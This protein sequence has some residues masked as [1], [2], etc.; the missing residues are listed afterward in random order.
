M[1][2]KLSIVVTINVVLFFVFVIF[3]MMSKSKAHDPLIYLIILT[4]LCSIPF[5]LA[6]K[7]NGPYC[8][9]VIFSPVYFIYF[10]MTDALGYFFDLPASKSSRGMGLTDTEMAILLGWICLIIGYVLAV[11]LFSQTKLKVEK[12]WKTKHL[13]VLGFICTIIGWYALWTLQLGFAD[14][15]SHTK[16]DM[17]PIKGMILIIG[18][19]L[20]P[21]GAVLLVYAYLKEKS[22]TL[23]LIFFGICILKIPLAFVLDSKEIALQNLII[24]FA[25]KWFYDGKVPVRWLLVFF[26]GVS[27]LFPLFYAYRTA[28]FSSSGVTRE[29]AMA[30]MTSNIDKTLRRSKK[31]TKEEGALQSGIISFTGRMHLKPLVTLV[32]SRTGHGVPYQEG[33]TLSLLLYALI[34]RVILPNKDDSSIGQLFNR[35]FRISEDRNTYISS[36]FLAEFYWNYGWGGIIIGMLAVGTSFGLIGVK[37][38]IAEHKSVTRLLVLITTIYLLCFRFEAGVAIQYTQWIRA[39]I[40][41]L[42]LHEIFARP[43]KRI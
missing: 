5:L 26:V 42:I 33:Y 14:H 31:T 7:L 9:L 19:M 23:L 1:K 30:S 21:F 22:Q 25:A 24:F 17:G 18:K 4:F 38:N 35:Q 37:G 3:S 29:Q 10:G 32:I 43:V 41:V 40:I 11:R 13:V 6:K 12:D 8:I 2:S 20:E 34:P 15:Y 28:V 36:S 39:L 16:V 27:L